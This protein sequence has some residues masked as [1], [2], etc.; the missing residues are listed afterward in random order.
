MNRRALCL[1][2][3]L[4]LFPILLQSQVPRLPAKLDELTV[5][6]V[7]FRRALSVG[8]RVRA[9]E[10]VALSGRNDFLNN[11]LAPLTNP[12]I[13]GIDFIDQEKVQVRTTGKLFLATGP[14]PQLTETVVTDIWIW[15]KN[16]WYLELASGKEAFLDRFS[17]RDSADTGDLKE[18][19]S[20]F[21]LQNETFDVGTLLQGEYKQVTV[22]FEYSGDVPIRIESKL[23]TALAAIQ[24][25]TTR[26]L[27]KASKGFAVIVG[28]D[29][30]EGPFRAP[31]RFVVY[32]K[33]VTFEQAVSFQG[34]I[35]ASLRYR[36]VP[37]TISRTSNENFE[38]FI[39]NAS[40]ADVEISAVFTDGKF[41]VN[42]FPDRIAPG[43]EASI[44]LRRNLAES[45]GS[46]V[47]IHLK[48][49]LNG[50]TIYEFKLR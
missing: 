30:F 35:K 1:I 17:S 19:K 12:R 31:V 9:S 25:G 7:E 28:S 40:T 23:D 5:R 24:S 48:Q 27:T 22:P 26:Q 44:S 50:K 10:F 16:N 8:D 29:D 34:V 46:T 21:K 20:T 18:I 14:T 39:A 4:F 45:P 3:T 2:L 47:A 37:E 11:P 38:L 42:R 36:Q 41:H 13:V 15:Q 49:P 32:Y 33:G 43:Q 6:A